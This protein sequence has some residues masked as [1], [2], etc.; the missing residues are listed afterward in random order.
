MGHETFEVYETMKL[1]LLDTNVVIYLLNGDTIVRK[2][3]EKAKYDLFAISVVSWIELLAG[4]LRHGQASA[5]FESRLQMFMRLPLHDDV[6]R[7]TAALIQSDSHKKKVFP[8][9][10]IAATALVNN[11]PLLTNNPRDFRKFKGIKIVPMRK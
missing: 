1:A 8:D 6:A 10:V 3:L 7:R 11:I 2:F 4:S 9:T 5:E